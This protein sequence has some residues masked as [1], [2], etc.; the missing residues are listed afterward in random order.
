[1]LN[2]SSAGTLAHENTFTAASLEINDTLTVTATL[3]LG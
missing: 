2:A 1:L 3:N